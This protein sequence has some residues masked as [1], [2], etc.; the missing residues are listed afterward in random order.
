MLS[1]S[2][3][4]KRT[5]ATIERASG[6]LNKKKQ[7]L[8]LTLNLQELRALWTNRTGARPLPGHSRRGFIPP[9]ITEGPEKCLPYPRARGLG[10]EQIFTEHLLC[11]RLRIKTHETQTLPLGRFS[12]GRTHGHISTVVGGQLIFIGPIW[13]FVPICSSRGPPAQRTG[14]V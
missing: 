6:A 10:F 11:A 7:I 12:G 2:L 1:S 4:N 3:K 8:D 9:G 5:L 13:W 14:C